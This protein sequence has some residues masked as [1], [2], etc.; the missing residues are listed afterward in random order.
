MSTSIKHNSLIP[1]NPFEELRQQ[2]PNDSGCCYI[3]AIFSMV[4]R[5]VFS[6]ASGSL[7]INS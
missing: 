7:L 3:N 6:L 4:P 1:I 2:K 5:D